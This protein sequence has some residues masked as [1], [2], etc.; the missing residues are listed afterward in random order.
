MSSKKA[1]FR[2]KH[3]PKNSYITIRIPIM[4]PKKAIIILLVIFLIMATAF[5]YLYFKKQA[6]INGRKIQAPLY[7]TN[8]SAAKPGG[9]KALTPAQKK[10]LEI[11][12]KTAEQVEKIAEEGKTESG[13]I[14]KDAAIRIEETINQAIAE[15]VKLKTP[16]QRK[17]EEQKQAEREKLEQELNRRIKN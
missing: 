11:K 7:K 13:G 6:F 5:A 3:R 9:E 8:N 1:H 10:V 14:T 15:E 17:E 16:E 2:K 12:S 4:T